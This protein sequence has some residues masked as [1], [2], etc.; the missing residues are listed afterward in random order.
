M[1]LLKSAGEVAARSFSPSDDGFIVKTTWRLHITCRKHHTHTPL[2]ADFR[3]REGNFILASVRVSSYFNCIYC[4]ETGTH[5]HSEEEP[6]SSVM[7]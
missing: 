1:Y 2:A 4:Q 3:K 5:M 6:Y 7:V